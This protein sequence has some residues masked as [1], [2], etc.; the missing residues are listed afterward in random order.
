MGDFTT[1]RT[2]A[3]T[4]TVHP[5]VDLARGIA[6][7]QGP[8]GLGDVVPAA[9][10]TRTIFG[11]TVEPIAAGS[12]GTMAGA[13]SWIEVASGLG[14]GD[15]LP[16]GAPLGVGADSKFIAANGAPTVSFTVAPVNAGDPFIFATVSPVGVTVPADVDP[17]AAPTGLVAV[18]VPG[19]VDLDWDDNAEGDLAGYKVWRSETPG[20]PYD[21]V[22]G[23]LVIPSAYTDGDVVAGTTYHYVVTAVDASANES[24]DSAEASATPPVDATPPAAPTGL[25]AISAG[26]TSVLLTW[27]ANGEPDLAGYNVKRA[28]I[29]GG[30]YAQLNGPLVLGTTYTDTG[31]SPGTTY[32]YVVTAV[33]TSTNESAESSEA[34]GAPGGGGVA[35]GPPAAPVGVST[36]DGDGKVV[37]TWQ[38]SPEAN[39]VSYTVYRATSAGGPYGPTPDSPI[40]EPHYVDSDVGTIGTTLYYRITA[41]NDA[42]QESPQSDPVPGAR[43]PLVDVIRHVVVA[44]EDGA[45]GV[46]TVTRAPFST[47]VRPHAPGVTSAAGV[48]KYWT[49]TVTTAFPDVLLTSANPVPFAVGDE[50]TLIFPNE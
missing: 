35:P 28:A 12:S 40:S 42:A 25:A 32:Y 19:F 20:G 18:A 7:E 11:V 26:P 50:V 44:G 39:V 41:T 3:H 30:P 13:Q 27:D 10:G 31:L 15:T 46:V 47:N 45:G 33:D 5:T 36:H 8:A 24:A 16:A 43:L 22:S 34:Q 49:G 1:Y 38:K 48:V 29:T 2:L 6:L 14:P 4:Q 21:L 9:A 37:L 23:S 17:P